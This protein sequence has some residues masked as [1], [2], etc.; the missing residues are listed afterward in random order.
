MEAIDGKYPCVIRNYRKDIIVHL[1]I[2]DMQDL[3]FFESSFEGLERDLP[4]QLDYL[5]NQMEDYLLQHGKEQQAS[6]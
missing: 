3:I 5:K 6:S 4:Q 2:H 1:D